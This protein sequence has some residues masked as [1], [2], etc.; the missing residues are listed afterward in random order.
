MEAK[1]QIYTELRG[2]MVRNTPLQER[3]LYVIMKNKCDN[4][5]SNCECECF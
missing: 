4:W 3:H 1:W 2:S 5:G